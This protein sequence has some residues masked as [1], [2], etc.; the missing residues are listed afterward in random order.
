[1]VDNPLITFFIYI[2]FLRWLVL[3]KL[4]HL[5]GA[6][7][8]VNTSSN[9]KFQS[10][11]EIAFL[12]VIFI[13]DE[14]CF[15]QK[16]QS[17]L[18]G[19]LFL[20]SFLGIWRKQVSTF[21]RC[22]RLLWA[23]LRNPTIFWSSWW[24]FSWCCSNGKWLKLDVRGFLRKWPKFGFEEAKWAIKIMQLNWMLSGKLSM[25]KLSWDSLAVLDF[26]HTQFEPLSTTHWEGWSRS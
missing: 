7:Q 23:E 11:L 17:I 9:I 10:F 1:M 22:I 13:C 2:V 19:Y 4:R 8:S 12:V 16:S 26:V 24:P 5:S 18:G 15:C 14:L 6:S 21:R 20:R 3:R 25:S